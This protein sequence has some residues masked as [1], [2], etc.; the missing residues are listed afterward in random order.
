MSKKT[1]KL[2]L[3]HGGKF[4]VNKVVGDHV[5]FKG[6]TST[7][8][9]KSAASDFA[10]F[11]G[12]DVKYTYKILLP[13]GSKGVCANDKN[14]DMTNFWHEHEYLL[15]KGLEGNI[16]DIDVKNHIVTLQV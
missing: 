10:N 14:H 15:D 3:Y 7:S 9:Q 12:L 5:K 8:F 13:A 2:V 4:D 16:V 1:Y 6:Y 11:D